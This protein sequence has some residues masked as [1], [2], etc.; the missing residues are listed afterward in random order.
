MKLRSGTLVS[1]ELG[2]TR[3]GRCFISLRSP[4]CV[5]QRRNVKQRTW[6]S[7]ALAVRAVQP[8]N[9][10]L[11]F[12]FITS[13][14]PP[15][16]GTHAEV[17]ANGVSNSYDY[18]V[19]G[20]SVKAV[21]T[22]GFR[23]CVA[24]GEHLASVGGAYGCGEGGERRAVRCECFFLSLS[25]QPCFPVDLPPTKKSPPRRRRGGGC[26][27]RRMPPPP[28]P[29]SPPKPPLRRPRRRPRRPSPRRP[30]A[31]SNNRRHR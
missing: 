23:R 18:H 27:V 12:P 28:P 21:R 31:S 6:V 30:A 24:I 5:K 15:E 1:S 20:G 22:T 16:N 11:F 10:I 3:S 4:K 26:S 7:L 19:W 29:R 17:F 25:F 9:S 2:K 8:K 13:F 14:P